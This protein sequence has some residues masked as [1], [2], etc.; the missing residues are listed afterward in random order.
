MNTDGKK[1][2][3]DILVASGKLTEEALKEAL[4]EQPDKHRKLGEII[5]GNGM[6]DE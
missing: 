5:V 2:I 4:R 3:G 1:K 6:A